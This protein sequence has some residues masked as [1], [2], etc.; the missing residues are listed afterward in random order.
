[1]CHLLFTCHLPGL[2][3][4]LS[5]VTE[6]VQIYEPNDIISDGCIRNCII[7]KYTAMKQCLIEDGC[8]ACIR[9]RAV[10]LISIL[11][12]NTYCLNPFYLIPTAY[13]DPSS[14]FSISTMPIVS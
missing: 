12:V 5:Y 10:S 13:V 1:M 6:Y 8:Y 11:R 7:A 4:F 3:Y 2:A 9:F 14:N